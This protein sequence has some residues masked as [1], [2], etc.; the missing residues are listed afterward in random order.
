MQEMF[1]VQ[2]DSAYAGPT[3]NFTTISFIAIVECAN[4]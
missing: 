4:V 3:P 2:I 1:Q